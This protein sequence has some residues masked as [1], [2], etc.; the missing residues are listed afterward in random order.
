MSLL[1]TVYPLKNLDIS[2]SVR[3][4]QYKILEIKLSTRDAAKL[5]PSKCAHADTVAKI[6]LFVIG[7][8][9]S[10]F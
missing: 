6:L 1:P 2:S 9:L 7:V 5:T 4:R 10:A 8:C 3:C